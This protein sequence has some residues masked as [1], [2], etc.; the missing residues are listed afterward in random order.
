M[1]QPLDYVVIVLYLGLVTAFGLK[2]GGK[3]KDTKDYFLGGRTLPWWAV[4][5]S[6]VATETSVLTVIGTPAI[7]FGGSMVF[8]QMTIGYLVA[9]VLVAWLLLPKYYQGEMT[10]AYAYLGQR[11]GAKMQ[12]SAS[13]V[14]MVTRLLADGVRL[15]AVSIPLKVASDAAGFDIPY[16]VLLLVVG[17]ITIGYS[18]SGGIKAVIWMDVVQMAVYTLAAIASI[19]VIAGLVEPG[20]FAAA[21][22]QGKTQVFDFQV[23]S[24]GALLTTPYSFWVAVFGGA[25]FGMASHGTDQLIVGR[26]LSTKNLAQS[27]LALVFS[28]FIVMAQFA[29]FLVLG[30]MLWAFYLDQVGGASDAVAALG[31]NRA[32]EIYPKFFVEVLPPG[33]SGLVLAGVLAAA[34]STL[35]S[36]LN[37]LSGASIEDV[38]RKFTKKKLDDVAA[39][40]ISRVM[41][42]VWGAVFI[43]FANLFTGMNNP[44]IELGLGIASFTYGGLLGAFL[45]ALWIKR[46]NQTGAIVAF[47][48]TIVFSV[49]MILGV[50][51]SPDTGW[52]F[53]LNQPEGTSGIAWPLYT[54]IGAGF[55]LVIGWVLSLFSKPNEKGAESNL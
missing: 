49:L 31:L 2:A 17:I 37:A 26:L 9:R 53:S 41:T 55:C 38:Y 20:W 10:T 14:F 32:D 25:I 30:L 24:L 42:L 35:S 39:L 23:E 6:V 7:T 8:F 52:V 3:Q 4:S 16:P 15:F 47:G 51:Y 44:V 18:W 46:L 5:L 33:V 28:G 27:R 45:V 34:M 11:F 13:V 29:L 54:A 36:S 21:T 12:A 48:L 22:E 50:W 19:W 43:G 1:L 40:R